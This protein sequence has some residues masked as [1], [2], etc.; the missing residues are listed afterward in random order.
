MSSSPEQ[1]LIIDDEAEL[2]FLPVLLEQAVHARYRLQ[3]IVL[4]QRLAHIE[5][6]VSRRI[7]AGQQLGD[8]DENLRVIRFLE[9]IDD[10]A[11]VFVL[12]LVLGII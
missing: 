9:S 1:A 7:E 8:D 6:R 12:G 5:H 11:I 10:L 2:L 4:S 3:Q